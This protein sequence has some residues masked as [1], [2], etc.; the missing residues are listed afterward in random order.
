MKDS[1]Y[2]KKTFYGNKPLTEIVLELENLPFITLNGKKYLKQEN[3]FVLTKT[4]KNTVLEY[5]NQPKD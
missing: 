2:T 5:F 3:V 4:H 1:Y